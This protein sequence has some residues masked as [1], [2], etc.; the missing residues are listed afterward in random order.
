MFGMILTFLIGF[1]LGGWCGVAVMVGANK[2][3]E[4]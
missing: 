4:R 1:M 3:K 2:E